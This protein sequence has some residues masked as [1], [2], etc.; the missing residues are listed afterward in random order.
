[1]YIDYNDSSNYSNKKAKNGIY[2]FLIIILTLVLTIGVVYL[3]NGNS[4][5]FNKQPEEEPEQIFLNETTLYLEKGK[6]EKLQI[7]F[8]EDIDNQNFTWKSSDSNVTVSN[9]G[10]VYANEVGTSVVTVTSDTGQTVTCEVVVSEEEIKL[11]DITIDV[12]NLELEVGDIYQFTLTTTPID[13]NFD[14]NLTWES[15]NS[16]VATIDDGIV[17]A[18]G[19]GNST[20]TVATTNGKTATC[21][22]IVKEKEILPTKVSLSASDIAIIEG[23]T[24]DLELIQEPSD[25]TLDGISWKS[26]DTSVAIVNEDGKINT[27][28]SGIAI[29]T[30]TTKNDKAASCIVIV[31]EAKV[32]I[33]A[34]SI[35]LN[36]TNVTLDLGESV[37]LIET[38][39]PNN[40]ENKDVTWTSSNTSVATVDNNGNVTSVG[41]G[42]TTITVKTVNDKIA[43]C[44]INVIKLDIKTFDQRNNAVVSYFSS[45]SRN[46]KSVYKSSNCNSSSNRCDIPKTYQTAITGNIKI[47]EYNEATKTKTYLKTVDKNYLPYNMVPNVIY[48]LESESN[49]NSNEYIKLTGD[50]RMINIPKIRNVRDIGGKKADGGTINYGLVYRGANPSYVSDINIATTIFQN[51][52]IGTVVDL[53]SSSDFRKVKKYYASLE[54]VNCV[55]GYFLGSTNIA[56]TRC[57]VETVMKSVVSGKGA[58]FHCA[59]GK[60]RTGTVAYLLEGLLGVSLEDRLDD[61]EL[62]YFYGAASNTIRTYS[63]IQGMSK[64]LSKYPGASDQERIISWYLSTSKNIE[65]DLELVNKFRST[66][67]NG[68]PTIYKIENGKI[69]AA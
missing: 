32:E 34:E 59:V 33:V 43:T 21:N 1:M 54:K 2:I 48:Y 14:L 27:L 63:S 28:Q 11:E 22:V 29:I 51:L 35:T 60:H 19:V 47:Y 13:L 67:I 16:S 55:A 6:S 12:E 30:A 44:T 25:A 50:T 57:G 36:K 17:K 20:I 62:S 52:G 3:V 65:N 69:V 5:S 42:T 58:Y 64:R 40:T 66:M 37:K 4:F 9:D 8:P 45:T 7:V 24:F 46:M 15:S 41:K 26:S 31:K 49:P 53:R 23:D 56:G 10:T 68:T 39:N 18:V 61:Y 38:I